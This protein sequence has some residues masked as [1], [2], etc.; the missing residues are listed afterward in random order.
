[1]ENEGYTDISG[2]KILSTTDANDTPASTSTQSTGE[3]QL[4]T[5]SKPNEQSEGDAQSAQSEESKETT[6]SS[7][8][9]ESEEDTQSINTNSK[10]EEIN[11]DES[12]VGDLLGDLSGGKINSIDELNQLIQRL[13]DAEKAEPKFRNEQ[14]KKVFEFLSKYNGSD[15][16][17]GLSDFAKLQSLDVQSM[18]SKTALKEWRI[19]ELTNRGMSKEEAESLFEY[20]YAKKYDSEGE[21]GEIL[22]KS[23]AFDAKNKLAQL[24]KDSLL[25]AKVDSQ[26]AEQQEHEAERSN[27]LS[28]VE[29]HFDNEHGQ[30]NELSFS[31]SDNPDEDLNFEIEN[32]QSVRSAVEDYANWFQGRYIHNGQYDIEALKVDIAIIQN[33]PSILQKVITHGISIGEERKVRERTNTPISNEKV[34]NAPQGKAVTLSDALM[35]ARF[36]DGN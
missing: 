13:E 9:V 1:M 34:S 5:D 4:S 35:N 18:D 6:T 26:A 20:E 15:Y 17:Q 22:L 29:K 21:I 2:L 11:L 12:Q 36:T 10:P 16:A 30:F 25:P 23:D 33:L 27:Y 19:Y 8:E 3:V 24:Q 14:E 31:F 28:E 7:T 32:P